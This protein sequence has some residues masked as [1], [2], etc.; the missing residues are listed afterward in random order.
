MRQQPHLKYRLLLLTALLFISMTSHA[1]DWFFNEHTYMSKTPSHDAPY[2]EITL[3]FFDGKGK[4]SYFDNSAPVV[5][6]DGKDLVELT[7]LGNCTEENGSNG[8]KALVDNAK[9]S[10]LPKNAGTRQTE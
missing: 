2:V 8:A 4:D 1:R 5:T 3:N 7:E 6:L 9:G 10:W